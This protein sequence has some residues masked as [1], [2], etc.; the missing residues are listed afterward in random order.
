MIGIISV[1]KV[2][3]KQLGIFFFGRKLS[4]SPTCVF[5]REK[6]F[7]HMVRASC[8]L[9]IMWWSSTTHRWRWIV[10]TFREKYRKHWK[11]SSYIVAGENICSVGTFTL[12]HARISLSSHKLPMSSWLSRHAPSQIWRHTQALHKYRINLSPFSKDFRVYGG[13][14]WVA[15]HDIIARKADL[16]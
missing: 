16:H 5:G 6:T 11:K 4:R 9:T 1:V 13:H 14:L 15:S 10:D 3:W 8:T 12:Y 7:C 2:F